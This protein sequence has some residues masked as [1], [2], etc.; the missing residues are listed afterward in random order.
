MKYLA[1]L[2]KGWVVLIPIGCLLACSNDFQA[3]ANAPSAQGQRTCDEMAHAAWL[4]LEA[5]VQG[6]PLCDGLECQSLD[7]LKCWD[8]CDTLA[9]RAADVA[10]VE[11]DIRAACQPFFTAGCKVISPPCIAV[12]TDTGASVKG[13]DGGVDCDPCGESYV[14]HA[15][16]WGSPEGDLLIAGYQGLSQGF[17]KRLENGTWVTLYEGSGP[18]TQ[19]WGTSSEDFFVSG[20]GR[21]TVGHYRAGSWEWLDLSDRL[22]LPGIGNGQLRALWGTATDDVF[23]AGSLGV[24]LHFDGITWTPM[25]SPTQVMLRALWGTAPNHVLAIGEQGTLLRYDG[26]TWSSVPTH[27]Q[28]NLN[29]LWGSS[30]DH[31]FIVGEV[32]SEVSHIIL[33]FD[34]TNVT[35]MH[36]GQKTL[37]GIHGSGPEQV[38]AV[39]AERTSDRINAGV[40]RFDGTRWNEEPINVQQFLWDVWVK[41]NGSYTAVGPNGTLVQR[42]I[43]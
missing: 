41:P 16:I 10:A 21:A 4:S 15:D 1:R 31:V 30:S 17:V 43:R 27:T 35:T 29:A 6:L 42:P 40:F 13:Q 5:T 32:T 18:L 33:H 14:V 3:G 37:L 28:A 38:Y 9:V 8:H 36:E 20:G 7:N 34:G 11:K 23:L 25:P 39:G 22:R 24:I 19:I 12:E 2:L 26:T